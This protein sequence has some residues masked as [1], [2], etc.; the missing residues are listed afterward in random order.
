MTDAVDLSISQDPGQPQ[1]AA[2]K[3]AGE[4]GLEARLRPV[5]E[6]LDK[7]RESQK[8]ELLFRIAAGAMGAGAIA[9]VCALAAVGTF[10]AGLAGL[11]VAVYFLPPLIAAVGLGIWAI[12]P[13]QL[14]IS[15]YKS[16]VLP[17][18][19]GTFGPF[20]YDES[21]RIGEDR[22]RGS[23]LLPNFDDYKSED[24][25]TGSYKG[26]DIELAEVKMTR[27]QGNDKDR[28]TVTLFKG[29][30]VLL[31]TSRPVDG[32][33]VI[34][35]DAGAIAN[36]LGE[37][38]GGMQRIP[39]DDPAFEDR[40][41]VHATDAVEARS[42][43]T[44][45][46]VERLTTLASRIGDGR[47]QAAFYDEQLLVMVPNDKDLFEPPSIFTSVLQDTG[48]TRISR[49]LGDVMSIIDILRL[50]GQTGA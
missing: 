33:T 5:L 11:F 12:Q 21:G 17:V 47:L 4:D 18:V 35:R 2:A 40:F 15:T 10:G 31:S 1:E 9:V 49:Q 25:F 36:W 14:Y 32:K 8:N 19:A 24:K 20:K 38:F 46:F 6:E 30:F 44:P 27:V 7:D 50:D 3:L 23:T 37:K 22:L 43:L 48:V 16:N 13:R 29:L 26:V 28:E 41:E 42:L 39:F 34:K 45:D